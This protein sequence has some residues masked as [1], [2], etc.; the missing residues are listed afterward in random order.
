MN[1]LK[2]VNKN[3]LII[4]IVLG[5]GVLASYVPIIRTACDDYWAGISKMSRDI[6]LFPLMISAAVGFLA[7]SWH[8]LRKRPSDRRGLFG[9]SKYSLEILVAC[10]LVFSI[11]WSAFVY[12][13]V[14]KR[15]SSSTYTYLTSATLIV[16]AFCS[17]L[18]LMGTV[19]DNA[20]A[21]AL[22]GIL[23]LSVVTVLVDGIAWNSNWLLHKG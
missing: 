14:M 11:M 17:V 9:S 3:L 5:V 13:S 20:P 23:A 15:R 16:V 4:I 12:L 10:L 2:F 6:V 8:Y 22:A 1:K 18:L 21:S 7:W 19:Q